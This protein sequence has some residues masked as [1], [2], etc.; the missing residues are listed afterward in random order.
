M[1]N[2]LHQGIGLYGQMPSTP[3]MAKWPLTLL[4]LGDF[5]EG[6]LALHGILPAEGYYCSNPENGNGLHEF[7]YNK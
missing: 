4:E 5:R 3:N 7:Y 2:K 1:L 6:A